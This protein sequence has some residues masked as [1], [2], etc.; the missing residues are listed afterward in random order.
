MIQFNLLPDVKLEYLRAKRLKSIMTAISLFV[1]LTSLSL[2]LVMLFT[3]SVI[4]KKNMSDLEKDIST[5]AN[6][7]LN[8]PNINRILTVQNQLQSLSTVHGSK[9]AVTRFFGYLSSVTP[10]GVTISGAKMDLV[11][12]T[13]TLS[14]QAPDLLSINRYV[15][16]LKF[17][18][19]VDTGTDEGNLTSPEAGSADTPAFTQVIL[20][21]FASDKAESTFQISLAFNPDIFN[22]QKQIKLVVPERITTRSQQ[23]AN[24]Q[25]T[26]ILFKEG[27]PKEVKD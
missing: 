10:S 15:D 5:A 17:T 18:T 6:T 26:D 9:P 7:V 22:N 24:K 16:T 19:F 1:G 14:G 27:A 12:N 4:Q 3:V 2:A 21:G 25:G 23:Q 13:L 8:T 20:G 11:G